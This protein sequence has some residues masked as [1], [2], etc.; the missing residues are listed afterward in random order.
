MYLQNDRQ[1]VHFVKY[2]TSNSQPFLLLKS[3]RNIFDISS[4][5]THPDFEPTSLFSFPLCC[6]LSGEVTNTYFIVFGLTRAR[7]DPKIYR[8]RGKHANHY[9]INADNKYIHVHVCSCRYSQIFLKGHLYI[10][11]HCL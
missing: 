9:A 2:K 11:N 1:E 10:A 4:P 8:T 5:L 6:M 3:Q 7:L